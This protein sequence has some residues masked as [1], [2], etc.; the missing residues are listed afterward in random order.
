MEISA[1]WNTVDQEIAKFDLLRHPFYQ[2]WS[3]GELTSRDLRFYAEQYFHQALSVVEPL[4][5]A[6]DP[7]PPR[8]V[9]VDAYSGLGDLKLQDARESRQDGAKRTESWAQARSWYLKS[10]DVRRR[11][12]ARSQKYSPP[13]R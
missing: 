7:D 10:I 1:F 13:H 11:K 4:L 6:K 12:R 2:A 3:A 5:S 8:Y 9:A